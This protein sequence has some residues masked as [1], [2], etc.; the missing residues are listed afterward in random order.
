MCLRALKCLP[1]AVILLVSTC[2]SNGAW[3]QSSSS[4]VELYNS[5]NMNGN[6]TAVLDVSLKGSDGQ[7]VRVAA[8]VTLLKLSK[9]VYKQETAKAGHVPDD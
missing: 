4:A 8:V 3:G 9:E 1:V 5:L 7:P 6:Q 2:W